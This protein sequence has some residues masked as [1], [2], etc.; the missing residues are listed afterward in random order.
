MTPAPLRIGLVCDL[1]EERWPSM[2]LVAE[3]LLARIPGASNHE[4]EVTRLRA[5]G[6]RWSAAAARLSGTRVLVNANRYADRHLRYPRWLRAHRGHYDVYHVV[7]H[8]YAHLV[9]ALPAERTIVTCHDIDAFRTLVDGDGVPRSAMFRRMTERILAGLQRAALVT[10]D[11]AATRDALVEHRL[12]TGRLEVVPLGVDSIFARAP[13]ASHAPTTRVTLLHVG[14]TVPRK[15]IDRL[16]RVFAGVRNA[17]M[18]AELVRV[19]GPFTAAQVK[20]AR[21]LGISDAIRILPPL[22]RGALA[23]VYRQAMLLLLPSDSEGF[24]L[25]VVEAMASGTPVLA[26]DLPALREVGGDATEYVVAEDETGW[27]EAI[28]RLT[29]ERLQAPEVW[30]QRRERCERQASRF[31]WDAC[32]RRMITLYH[33]VNGG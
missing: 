20:L 8:T 10:C 23:E 14:S 11:S 27:V 9:H 15:R 19:G 17:G 12:R 31:S 13:A 2:D 32:A 3:M 6:A 29:A 7:D 4:V 22:D 1:L 5:T 18:D 33:E 30:E 21:A 24:G 25:P 26:S 28:Q 16:L